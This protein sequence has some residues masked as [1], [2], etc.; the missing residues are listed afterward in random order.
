MCIIHWY[1]KIYF[2]QCLLFL[3]I[4]GKSHLYKSKFFLWNTNNTITIGVKK[5]KRTH[6]KHPEK[7]NTGKGYLVWKYIIPPTFFFKQPPYFINPSLFKN[8]NPPFVK[9]TGLGVRGEVP[10]MCLVFKIIITT[11]GFVSLLSL[12]VTPFLTY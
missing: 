2:P 6:T 5:T 1:K 3:K 8:S 10:T 12:E 9:G 4:T 7:D 11:S